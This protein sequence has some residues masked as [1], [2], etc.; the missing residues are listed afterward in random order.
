MDL[1]IQGSAHADIN[2]LLADRHDLL[3]CRSANIGSVVRYALRRDTMGR[4]LPDPSGYN[5]CG[6]G[7]LHSTH[8]GPCGD[9]TPPEIEETADQLSELWMRCRSCR[10]ILDDTKFGSSGWNLVCLKAK[11]TDCRARLHARIECGL[12]Q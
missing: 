4:K 8:R 3:V 7:A 11:N 10:Y 5:P 9:A 6:N 12:G 2:S 1:R